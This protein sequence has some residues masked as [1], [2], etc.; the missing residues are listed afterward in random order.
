MY[1][2]IMIYTDAKISYEGEPS[3]SKD[4]TTDETHPFVSLE[5][6]LSPHLLLLLQRHRAEKREVDLLAREAEN[7]RAF[8]EGEEQ[9]IV[10]L[11]RI[12]LA[13]IAKKKERYV[14]DGA[15]ISLGQTLGTYSV[16]GYVN[17]KGG[18]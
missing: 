1:L 17:A 13:L 16:N 2:V 12:S 4:L 8:K 6:T 7:A 14:N 9:L 10:L 3:L 11:N 15:L 5:T 18:S